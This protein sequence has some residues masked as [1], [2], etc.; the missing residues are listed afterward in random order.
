MKKI[1]ATLLLVSNCLFVYGQKQNSKNYKNTTSNCER[2]K[3]FDIINYCFP[4]F[5]GWKEC[6]TEANFSNYVDKLEYNSNIIAFYIP[7]NDYQKSKNQQI[8][9]FPTLSIFVNTNTVGK[10]INNRELDIAFE[11]MKKSFTKGAW[12]AVED[13]LRSRSNADFSKPILIDN[14]SINSSIKTCVIVHS[15]SQ[16]YET[17]KRISFLNLINIK[18]RMVVFNYA[19]SLDGNKIYSEYS[20]KN[21]KYVLSFYNK[22][23]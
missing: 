6:R 12:N 21:E 1:L 16:N 8:L 9:N 7:T 20:S 23:F 13:A 3:Y 19:E 10:Y 11:G 17:I 5:T 15:I 18:N 22:N 4:V 2:K 14:Y